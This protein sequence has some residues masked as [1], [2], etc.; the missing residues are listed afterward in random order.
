MRNFLTTNDIARLCAYSRAQVWN[1]WK[2]GLIPWRNANP[3]GKQIRF[4][5]SPEIRF[6]CDVKRKRSHVEVHNAFIEGIVRA[7]IARDYRADPA[8]FI[9]RDIDRQLRESEDPD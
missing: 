8:R 4:I 5:D 1:W 9:V 6:W 3:R 2:A 7:V